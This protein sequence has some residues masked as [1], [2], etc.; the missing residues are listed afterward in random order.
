MIF[1]LFF[2]IYNNFLINV[3]RKVNNNHSFEYHH[4]IPGS[5]KDTFYPLNPSKPNTI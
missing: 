4:K 1:L 3:L 2:I 5:R